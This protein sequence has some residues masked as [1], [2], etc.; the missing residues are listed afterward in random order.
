MQ[1]ED[2]FHVSLYLFDGDWHHVQVTVFIVP[3]I[4]LVLMT[5]YFCLCITSADSPAEILLPHVE[6][7]VVLHSSML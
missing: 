2:K 4:E 5:D 1:I 7:F 3:A 6:P